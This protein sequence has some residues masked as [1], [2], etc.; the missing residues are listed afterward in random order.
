MSHLSSCLEPIRCV[1]EAKRLYW[2]TDTTPH[3]ALPHYGS[4]PVPRQF[5]R[6]VAGGLALWY[7][8]HSTPNPMVRGTLKSGKE[9]PISQ[10][11]VL[12]GKLWARNLSGTL[13]LY[14]PFVCF[15]VFSLLGI[16]TVQCQGGS[17]AQILGGPWEVILI[18]FNILSVKIIQVISQPHN[19]N[20]PSYLCVVIFF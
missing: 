16:F 14:W 20:F 7:S 10:D 1:L 15:T 13:S 9:E 2:I 3:E 17:R 6:V 4:Q 12:S 19:V 5:F 18:W 11:R 8:Q